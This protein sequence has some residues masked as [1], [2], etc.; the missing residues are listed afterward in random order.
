[1]IFTYVEGAM[2]LN[3]D[4]IHNLIPI[5]LTKQSELDTWEQWNILQ[6]EEW[7]FKRK[8]TKILSIE[9]VQ[10]LY[11]KMFDNTWK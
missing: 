10:K 5:H 9:F 6:A 2:P 1:M 3:H 4:E 8:R 7:V 11:N